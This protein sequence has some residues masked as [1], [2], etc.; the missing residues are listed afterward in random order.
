MML[1]AP[2]QVEE[3]L[4]DQEGKEEDV[5]EE[6]AGHQGA[7]PAPLPPAN[8]CSAPTP[9]PPANYCSAPAILNRDVS[10]SHVSI[11]R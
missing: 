5:A 3:G 7:G 9:L 11:Y 10:Y 2:L 8:Y 4:L 6:E 1:T